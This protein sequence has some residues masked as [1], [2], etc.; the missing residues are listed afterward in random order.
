MYVTSLEHG[1]IH[2]VRELFID[3]KPWHHV[4]SIVA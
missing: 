4:G 3:D 2:V 1:E